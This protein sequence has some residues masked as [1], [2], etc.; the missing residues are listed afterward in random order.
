VLESSD[1]TSFNGLKSKYSTVEAILRKAGWLAGGDQ[2][3]G[4]NNARNKRARERSLQI[5]AV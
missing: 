3:A 1:A 4:G 5:G 2:D